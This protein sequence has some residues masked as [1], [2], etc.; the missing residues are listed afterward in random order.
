MVHS[1]PALNSGSCSVFLR[2]MQS[3][4]YLQKGSLIF[5]FKCPQH[6]RSPDRFCLS[7]GET[8]RDTW[9]GNMRGTTEGGSQ[10]TLCPGSKD[11]LGQNVCS[12][13]GIPP[14]SSKQLQMCAWPT[15]TVHIWARFPARLPSRRLSPPRLVFTTTSL[16]SALEKQLGRHM[17]G[18]D[19][20]SPAAAAPQY[21]GRPEKKKKK[22]YLGG[23]KEIL[24]G[25]KFWGDF[26]RKRCRH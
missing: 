11:S 4:V 18:G 9:G 16:R 23:E 24:G 7:V 8:A 20:R 21:R 22:H 12:E 26:R 17:A 14:V 10:A 19:R 13:R 6:K 15:A 3:A 25:G 1:K 5:P 2:L